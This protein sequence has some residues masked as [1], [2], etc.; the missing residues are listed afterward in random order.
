MAGLLTHIPLDTS[1]PFLVRNSGLCS[2][3]KLINVHSS[4]SVQDLHLI[5]FSPQPDSRLEGTKTVPKLLLFTR[6]MKHVYQ[7]IHPSFHKTWT[8]LIYFLDI[9]GVKTIDTYTYHNPLKNNM[10]VIIIIGDGMADE[11]IPQLGNKTPLQVAHTPNMDYLATHGQTGVLK[12]VPDGWEVGSDVANLSILGYDVNQIYQGRSA[13]EAASLGIQLQGDELALRCNLITIEQD[14]ITSFTADHISTE[15]AIV[16]LDCLNS[17]FQSKGF[18]FHVG[19]YYRHLLVCPSHEP[20]LTKS[21]SFLVGTSPHNA[22][23]L[24]KDHLYL[25]ASIPEAEDLANKLNTLIL[26]SQAILAKHPI[27]IKRISDGKKPANAIS[28]WSPGFTPRMNP[29]KSFLPITTGSVISAVDLIKGIGIYAGLKVIEVAG[30]TGRTNTNYEGKVQAAI[31]ALQTDDFVWLHLEA[32]DEAS[33]DGDY[34]LKIKTIEDLDSRVIHPLLE[35]TKNWENPP[36]IAV[37]PD[38]PTSSLAKIHLDQKVPFIIYHPSITPDVVRAYNE[39]SCLEGLYNMEEGTDFIPLLFR[40]EKE[41][42]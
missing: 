42:L 14:K 21:K 6:I 19:E 16:L 26:E 23:D 39:T 36:L 27:N 13:F 38:H 2:Y 33:H 32:S 35:A 9:W 3:L 22:L 5:P 30:A 15:E 41:V 1:F 4:G 34:Q 24:T 11:P 10:S 28:L 29:L 20:T 25:K 7:L 12:T 8:I 40:I 37:L 18:K 17:H 31:Q